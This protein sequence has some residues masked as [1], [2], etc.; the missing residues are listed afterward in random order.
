[1]VTR[2]SFG[3]AYQEVPKPPSQ[4]NFPTDSAAAVHLVTSDTEERV[5]PDRVAATDHLCAD[6][7]DMH[8]APPADQ[9]DDTGNLAAFDMVRHDVVHAAEPRLGQSS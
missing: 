8:L 2:F 6:R 5:T 3:S 1:M 9:R 4:P 7:V